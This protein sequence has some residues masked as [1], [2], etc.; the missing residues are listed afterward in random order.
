[1]IAV[2]LV[3]VAVVLICRGQSMLAGVGAWMLCLYALF[4]GMIGGLLHAG[5]AA[6]I[7]L[8]DIAQNSFRR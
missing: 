8:R 1:M 6:C 7:A 3:I 5:A 2:F 4:P